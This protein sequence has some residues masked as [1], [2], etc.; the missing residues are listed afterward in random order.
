[1][2][3]TELLACSLAGLIISIATG[4]TGGNSA[5]RVITDNNRGSDYRIIHTDIRVWLRDC[6]LWRFTLTM[7]VIA[8]IIVILKVFVGNLLLVGGKKILYG[9]QR[10][11][12]QSFLGVLYGFKNSCEVCTDDVFKRDLYIRFCGHCYLSC[13]AIVK[14]YE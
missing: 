10:V 5:R 2:H 3:F 7:L 13:K 9:E 8:L 4:L 11:Q 1:M 12:F 6:L 14:A